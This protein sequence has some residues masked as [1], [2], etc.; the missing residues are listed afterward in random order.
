MKSAER[1]MI[2]NHRLIEDIFN[3][4]S[5]K[6]KKYSYLSI[7]MAEMFKKQRLQLP[8]ICLP[9]NNINNDKHCKYLS[10]ASKEMINAMEREKEREDHQSWTNRGYIQIEMLRNCGCNLQVFVF[11]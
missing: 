3:L 10:L 2:N 1:E 5:A 9:S 11:P 6:R 7:G 4:K 8:S